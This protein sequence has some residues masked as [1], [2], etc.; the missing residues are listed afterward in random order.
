MASAD[1]TDDARNGNSDNS[2][3]TQYCMA[4]F[5]HEHHWEGF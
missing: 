5:G 1:S 2:R 4:S 3:N